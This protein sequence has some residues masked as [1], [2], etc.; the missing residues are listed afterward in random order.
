MNSEYGTCHKCGNPLEPVWFQEEEYRK[1]TIGTLIKTG[2]TRTACSHL[3]C[4]RCFTKVC[5]DDTFDGPWR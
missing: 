2:R 5:V 1:G 3:E 4:P